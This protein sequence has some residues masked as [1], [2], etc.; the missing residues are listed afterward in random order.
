[1]YSDGQFYNGYSKDTFSSQDGAGRCGIEKLGGF[2]ARA[3]SLDLPAARRG[4]PSSRVT[5]SP[6]TTSSSA[7]RRRG[8]TVGVGD[9]LLVRTGW[10]DIF[11]RHTAE[12]TPP[13]FAQPGL[14]LS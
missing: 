2:A 12:G 13:P 11:E 6:A 7:L 5:G 14:A 3:V 9:A 1:M 8:S 4:V 10:L